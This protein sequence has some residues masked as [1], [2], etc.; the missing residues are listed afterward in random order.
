[1]RHLEIVVPGLLDHDML[2]QREAVGA[3]A[4]PCLENLLSVSR[5]FRFT[6]ISDEA[7]IYSR[8]FDVSA[9]AAPAAALLGG[10]S[11]QSLCL[12]PVRISIGARGG[13]VIPASLDE[14]QA[15]VWLSR[16]SDL[17]PDTV[18]LHW[19]DPVFLLQGVDTGDLET[20]ALSQVVSN[21][22]MECKPRGANAPDLLRLSTEFEMR[23]A[24]WALENDHHPDNQMTVNG[25][26]AWGEGDLV[27]G[28]TP[29]LSRLDG[30]GMAAIVQRY[31]RDQAD[32]VGD[33]ET[34]LIYLPALSFAV[35]EADPASWISTLE[36]YE[37]EVF[38]PVW[39]D[40]KCRSLSSVQVFTDSG[41]GFKATRPSTLARWLRR[42]SRPGLKNWAVV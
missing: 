38:Q 7:L 17:L 35:A 9:E 5:A 31:L 11:G 23:L 36:R 22:P 20:R 6:A 10:K 26:W 39:N 34:E 42:W 18:S 27:R 32:A 41:R 25:F 8:A 1:M 12:S 37:C 4:V 14:R 15:Q 2:S 28:A 24:E 19:I 30:P 13:R 29:R 40:L 16:C 3:A 21:D 33:V